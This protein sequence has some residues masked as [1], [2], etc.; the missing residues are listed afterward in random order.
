MEGTPGK[1]LLG[2]FITALGVAMSLYH[3]NIAYTGGYETFLQRGLS[4]LFA[5][6]MI[7][8]IYQRPVPLFGRT[9]NII[10]SG[11]TFLLAVASVGWLLF[12]REYFLDRF[13]YIH[14]PR[15]PDLLFGA[16]TI[17][18]VLEAARRTI[19]LTLPLISLAFLLYTYFGPYM[20]WIL[21]HKGASFAHIIDH[22]YMTTSGLWTVPL[23]VFTTYIFLFI[24]FGAFLG[25]MGAADFYTKLSMSV[26]GGLWGG[27]AKGAVIASAMLGMITGSTN[28]NVATTGIFTIPMMK[29]VGFRPEMAAGIET[30]AS[31]GGQIMPPVMGVCAF[32]IVEFT[33]VS[34]WEILKVSI[35]PALLYFFSVFMIVHLEARKEG[36]RGLPRNELPGVKETLR[37]GW[38]FLLPP[39]VIVYFLADGKTIPYCGLA[40]IL[41]I[42]LLAAVCGLLKLYTKARCGELRAADI[43][44]AVTAGIGSVI[45]ALEQGARSSLPIAAAVAAVGLVMGALFQTGLGVKF[46]SLVISLA[47]GSLLLGILLVGISSFV[48][49]MGL[50]TS[51]AYIVLSVMAVPALIELG[52]SVGLTLLAAHL[53]VFWYSLDSSFTPPVCVPAYTAAGIA[54]GN[55]SRA[56]WMAL[57]TAKGMYILPLMFAYT[58]ILLNGSPFR[59]IETLLCAVLGFL[60]LAA[61]LQAFL[62][63]PLSSA[64][65]MLL[66]LASLGLFWPGLI[67]HASGALLLTAVYLKQRSALARDPLLEHQQGY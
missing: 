24:L 30:A 20:P 26:M 18:F 16:L 38:Y 32:L 60:A 5:L 64:G 23:G 27:P 2:Y 8:L 65:R 41:T 10:F 47:N 25:R 28:A 53:I 19:N 63:S 17:F 3:L 44:R 55:P 62:L 6:A 22:H 35:F 59:V 67:Y 48:L 4:L 57:K 42:V 39:L 54:G 58:P 13:P 36:L 61:C 15:W 31:V 7:F 45:G 50:P 9:A 12:Q 11:A 46:S 1:R 43:A 66:A 51:A 37:E 52:Q 21:A 29:K 34:Y 56:A 14:P 40:G 33:G 49:G